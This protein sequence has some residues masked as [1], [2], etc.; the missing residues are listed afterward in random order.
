MM[1]LLDAPADT[2]SYMILGFG[3]ILGC[4]ALYI[5]SLAFRFRRLHRE[6]NMYKAIEMG[7][8]E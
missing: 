1:T 6:I 8:D 5:A 4:I 2:L 7:D 3:V